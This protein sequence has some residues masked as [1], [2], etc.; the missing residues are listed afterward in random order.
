M[1]NTVMS[2]REVRVNARS[3]NRRLHPPFR[4]REPCADAELTCDV[5]DE[6]NGPHTKD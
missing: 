5:P 1:K 2:E 6:G 3:V 4:P